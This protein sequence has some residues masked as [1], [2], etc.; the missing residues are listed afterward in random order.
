MTRPT[1][2]QILDNNSEYK[3]LTTLLNKSVENYKSNCTDENINK[4]TKI[5]NK[6]FN[7]RK[8]LQKQHKDQYGELETIAEYDYIVIKNDKLLDDTEYKE[9]L[10]SRFKNNDFNFKEIRQIKDEY[11]IN[12][13]KIFLTD[14]S[15]HAVEPCKSIHSSYIEHVKSFKRHYIDKDNKVLLI[16]N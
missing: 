4:M 3:S 10:Y 16:M 2:Q 1:F 13:N 5:F 15:F 6:Q 11:I 9:Y 12:Y 14:W 8:Q 7:L